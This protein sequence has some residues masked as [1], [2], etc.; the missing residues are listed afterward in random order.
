MENVPYFEA[1]H[2]VTPICA[3]AHAILD[4]RGY[5]HREDQL[6]KAPSMAALAFL[7]L[8]PATAQAQECAL[9]YVTGVSMTPAQ[10]NRM[11]VPV[12]L[13]GAPTMMILD[14]GGVVSQVTRE[15]I[16][17]MNL[18]ERR[19]PR[20]VLDI[21]GNMSRTSARVQAFTL[22]SLHFTDL[23]L[24]VESD[25]SLGGNSGGLVSTDLLARY[26]VD[27]DFGSNRLNFFEPSH[28]GKTQLY[29]PTEPVAVVP[30]ALS[31]FHITVPMT[32][33]GHR[34]SAV[35]DTGAPF[36]TLNLDAA[37]RV[38][39]LAP[40]KL[41]VFG[42]GGKSGPLQDVYT[43]RFSSMILE[44]IAV[45]HPQM[46][47]VPFHVDS[48]ETEPLWG[49][50]PRLQHPSDVIIGMDVLRTLHIYIAYRERLLYVTRADSAAGQFLPPLWGV[51]GDPAQ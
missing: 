13:N 43:H 15:T 33:D 29:W 11:M 35:L 10:P 4:L 47:I 31:D 38:F 25:L 28:C 14:T 30:F 21:L 17:T 23:D 36:T 16:D 27:I 26:D 50:L 8:A 46:L 42:S 39:D 32:L 41:Q 1:P 3:S 18:T 49:H 19:S 51:K 37:E 22:G 44:G 48:E 24:Q 6:D 40:G 12:T 45:A 9:H 34:M 5:S 7:T 20:R 2:Q